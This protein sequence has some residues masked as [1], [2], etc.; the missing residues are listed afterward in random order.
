[1]MT[2]DFMDFKAYPAMST[3][4][5]CQLDGAS[6]DSDLSIEGGWVDIDDYINQGYWN[7]V[8]IREGEAKYTKKKAKPIYWPVGGKPHP[9][10]SCV[11]HTQPIPKKT[12][13]RS[14]TLSPAAIT[15]PSLSPSPAYCI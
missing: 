3:Q 7:E 13:K 14:P 5:L 11:C 10:A 1:M 9:L 12:K 6:E 15:P 8:N 2:C 4:T